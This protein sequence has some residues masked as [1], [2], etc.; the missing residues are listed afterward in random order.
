[1][2]ELINVKWY[3]QNLPDWTEIIASDCPIVVLH[4]VM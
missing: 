2:G 3:K 1:M 4:E